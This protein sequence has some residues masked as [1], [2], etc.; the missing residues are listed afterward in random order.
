M[1][2]FLSRIL[3]DFN[4]DEVNYHLNKLRENLPTQCDVML[5]E[6]TEKSFMVPPPHI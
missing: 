3:G 6:N 5:P 1:S 4:K 2:R